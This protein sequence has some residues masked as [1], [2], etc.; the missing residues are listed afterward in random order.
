[1]ADLVDRYAGAVR[2]AIATRRSAETEAGRA[3]RERE[4][5]AEAA[6]VLGAAERDLASAA[7]E[8]STLAS[9]AACLLYTS[10]AAA[11]RSSVDLGGRRSIKKKKMP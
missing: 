9:R 5:A 11:E 1:M 4:R 3:D 8:H 6:E 2:S 7:E 10:D